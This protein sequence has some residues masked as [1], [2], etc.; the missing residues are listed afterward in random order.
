MVLRKVERGGIVQAD[1]LAQFRQSDAFAVTR[2]LL[3]DRKG[4]AER[5]DADPLPVVGV[6]VDIVLRRL[7][8][9]GD[10]GLAR[11]G[12]LLGGLLLGTRSH[13]IKPPCDGAELCW[14]HHWPLR[15]LDTTPCAAA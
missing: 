10:G 14:R 9:L 15:R 1:Q 4:A 8:Q 6:V 7:H 12:R 3:E 2:D 5:L 11:T 13:G